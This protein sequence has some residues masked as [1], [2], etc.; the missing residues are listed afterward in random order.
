MYNKY[1]YIISV[2]FCNINRSYSG[3]FIVFFVADV[4]NT[5]GCDAKF[6]LIFGCVRKGVEA[7][8]QNLE[9]DTDGTKAG[10][11]VLHGGVDK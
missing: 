2:K 7:V 8:I 1:T 3:F 5:E 4:E 11:F 6:G 10:S 9:S